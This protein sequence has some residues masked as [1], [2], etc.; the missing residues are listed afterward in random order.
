MP[1]Q[2]V[3]FDVYSSVLLKH[4]LKKAGVI[5]IVGERFDS[6][7]DKQEVEVVEFGR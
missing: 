1:P 6:N 3:R 5:E 4:V 7:V 2:L